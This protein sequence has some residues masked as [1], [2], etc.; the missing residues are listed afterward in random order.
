M[1]LALMINAL[2]SAFLMKKVIRY[3]PAR[4]LPRAAYTSSPLTC[5]FSIKR[6][7]LELWSAS[8]TKAI[9][10]SNIGKVKATVGS[11]CEVSVQKGA[12]E[13]RASHSTGQGKRHRSDLSERREG[14][15]GFTFTHFSSRLFWVNQP[16]ACSCLSSN[17]GRSYISPG[18]QGGLQYLPRCCEKSWCNLRR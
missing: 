7:L 17:E 12:P 4:V 2:L 5:P 9:S 10:G 11:C 8:S 18:L 15:Q 1:S 13:E 3:L 16:L 6:I 14:S